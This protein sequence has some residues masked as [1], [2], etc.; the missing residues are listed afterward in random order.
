MAII[1][2]AL[3]LNLHAITWQD[4]GL[5]PK[6]LPYFCKKAGIATPEEALKWK[7]Y[8]FNCSKA[9]SWKSVKFKKPEE[10]LKWKNA[11]FHPS[12]A[13]YW[14]SYGFN[15]EEAKRWMST[16]I[17][18]KK[19]SYWLEL[20]KT[21]EEAKKWQDIG[22]HSYYANF[23]IQAGVT[24]PEKAKEWQDIGIS[25]I[26]MKTWRSS[27]IKT[28]EE[29]KKWLD[30]G[31][32]GDALISL[33]KIGISDVEELKKWRKL[34]FSLKKLKRWKT[35]NYTLEEA[36]KWGH[37]H[38]LDVK[39]YINI[40]ITPLEVENLRK[41]GFDHSDILKMKKLDLSYEKINGGMLASKNEL[42]LIL[43]QDYQQISEYKNILESIFENCTG[44]DGNKKC[45]V[46]LVKNSA[47]VIDNKLLISYG[48]FN[49]NMALL[50]FK[51]GGFFSKNKVPDI[52]RSINN[53]DKIMFVVVYEDG[54]EEIDTMG[55][56]YYIP[57]F[58][59]LYN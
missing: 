46:L 47:K 9:G 14:R 4:V 45:R 15:I 8:G 7:E 25:C 10:A 58:G 13:R 53:R 21:P 2:F 39:N 31:V 22:I 16:G 18:G 24:T 56:D 48:D 35:N 28:P 52:Y 23:C 6:E 11:G 42:Q 33:R 17:K 27:K 44:Y 20:G 38:I 36:K 37:L 19:I 50:E 40:D 26:F 3:N 55:G 59:V 5:A 1:I 29:A 30:V 12:S 49:K 41:L 54:Q 57:L 43:Q 51:N 32:D 34:N